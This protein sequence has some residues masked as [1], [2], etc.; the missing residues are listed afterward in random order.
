MMAVIASSLPERR[1][2]SDPCVVH[3]IKCTDCSVEKFSLLQYVCIKTLFLMGHF[4]GNLIPD[5][6]MSRVS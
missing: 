6:R 1:M 2:R 3:T 5:F 4:H